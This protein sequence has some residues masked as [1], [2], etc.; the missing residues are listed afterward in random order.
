MKLRMGWFAGSVAAAL[1]GVGAAAPTVRA[2]VPTGVFTYT[3]HNSRFGE[4]GVYTNVVRR[5]G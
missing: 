4:V 1:I 2:E 5:E 3:I